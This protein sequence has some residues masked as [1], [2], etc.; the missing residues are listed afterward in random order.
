[1]Q[2][3]LNAIT[4]KHTW[5]IVNIS[6]GKK[7]VTCR[8]VYKVKY[9]AYG[10]VELYRACLVAKRF[11][12]QEDIVYYETFSP[13][14]KSSTVRSIIALVVKNKWDI[15]H[16]DVNNV[17]LHGDLHASSS[18]SYAFFPIPCLSS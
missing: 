11:T 2:A 1:M 7:P 5:D 8:W 9:Q 15:H 10:S 12:Q 6:K 16:F 14:V 13:V 17:F 4:K 18:R 3:E